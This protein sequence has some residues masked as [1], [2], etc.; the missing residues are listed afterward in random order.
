[1]AEAIGRVRS[2][3]NKKLLRKGTKK[4]RILSL[5]HRIAARVSSI[6]DLPLSLSY[7]PRFLR[8]IFFLLF[9][10]RFISRAKFD[11]PMNKY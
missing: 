10:E 2:R 1:M 11:R 9:L 6:L 5:F 4:R 3:N 7:F 8:V